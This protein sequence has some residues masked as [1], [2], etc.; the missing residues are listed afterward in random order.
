MNDQF[1][2]PYNR[3]VETQLRRQI[4]ERDNDIQEYGYSVGNTGGYER[5]IVRGAVA[6][7]FLLQRAQGERNLRGINVRVQDSESSGHMKRGATVNGW[8]FP[9]RRVR[10]YQ[11]F[12]TQGKWWADEANARMNGRDW[13]DVSRRPNWRPQDNTV[14]NG[15]P[16]RLSNWE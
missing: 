16:E 7:P 15:L 1:G 13:F 8:R 9:D 2:T 3:I 10:P 5:D 6:D 14:R 4:N 12:R 11:F